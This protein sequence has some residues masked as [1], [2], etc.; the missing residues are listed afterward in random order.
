M[1]IIVDANRLGAFLSDPVNED[2]APVRRWLER[3]GGRRVYSTGG[4]FEQE[5]ERHVRK[6]L[7]DYVRAGRASLIPAEQYADDEHAL[8]DHPDLRSDDPHVLA[9][10]RSTGVRLLYTARR[11]PDRRLQE[12]EVRRRPEGQGL[13]ASSQ[14]GPADQGGVRATRV[15]VTG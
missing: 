3:R 1:C 10:A 7:L 6:K 11:R 15:R 9:L 2:A 4:A 12:Q 13:F 5:V 8:R 14:C